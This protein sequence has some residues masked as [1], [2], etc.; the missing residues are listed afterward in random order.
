MPTTNQVVTEIKLDEQ[1]GSIV[2]EPNNNVETMNK[3]GLGTSASKEDFH[4]SSELSLEKIRQLHSQFSKDRNWDQFHSPRNLLLALVGEVGEVSEHF[5]WKPDSQCTHGLPEWSDSDKDALG[6]ELSDV[7]IYLVRLADRCKVDLPR[8]VLSKMDK[9]SAKYP[10]E[11]A[12][13]MSKKYNE[14]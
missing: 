6:E 1:N 10:V 13:G 4:F 8:A 14:L 3:N 5:Q 9:N 11:K 7:L 12:F 2:N